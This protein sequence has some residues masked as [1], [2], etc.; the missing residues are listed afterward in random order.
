[1]SGQPI[2]TGLKKL[3]SNH[4]AMTFLLAFYPL[5]PSVVEIHTKGYLALVNALT[6]SVSNMD[7]IIEI[8]FGKRGLK[9]YKEYKR[10]NPTQILPSEIFEALYD[11]SDVKK[12]EK[13]INTMF[14][15]KVQRN[16]LNSSEMRASVILALPEILRH[17]PQGKFNKFRTSLIKM[18]ANQAI[19]DQALPSQLAFIE[20]AL[21]LLTQIER[22]KKQME[23][24]KLDAIFASIEAKIKAELAGKASAFTAPIRTYSD[25]KKNPIILSEENA[26]NIHEV[27]LLLSI[28]PA[29]EVRDEAKIA[30][31]ELNR[32]KNENR[33][34]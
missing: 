30:V 28:S 14:F 20:T 7:E 12:A 15:D 26:H 19:I 8:M 3:Y 25:K 10:N 27:L 23:E 33:N 34:R 16:F 31:L 22:H 29:L 17:H 1:M 21:R 32:I 18:M 9:A 11:E 24:E 4:G 13:L 6:G 2:K 5:L